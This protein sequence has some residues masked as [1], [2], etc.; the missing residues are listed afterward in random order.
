MKVAGVQELTADR[1]AS[2]ALEQHIV[3]QGDC[4]APAGLEHRDDVLQEV[5]LLVGGG[6]PEVVADDGLFLA[7]HTAFVVDVGHR[8]LGPERRVREADV[9]NRPGRVA[10][11][12][13]DDDA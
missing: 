7:G 4:G 1:L 6:D 8:R 12:I 9:C 2:A 13:S 3:G 5:Q 10:Q 11:S